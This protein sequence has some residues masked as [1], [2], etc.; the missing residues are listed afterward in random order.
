LSIVLSLILKPGQRVVIE[1]PTYS[2]IIN[3]LRA[4]R[5]DFAAV[6]LD[7]DGMDVAALESVLR[8]G[9]CGAI[10]AIPTFHNPT[11]ITM[12]HERRLHLLRLA[13]QYGVPIVEDDWGPDLHYEGKRHSPLKSLDRGGYVIHIGTYS[14][15]FLPGLRLGWITCPSRMA[16]ALLSA[17]SSI[18]RGDSFFL[19]ALMCEFI[20]RGHYARHLRHCLG[21]YRKR[22]NAL[23]RLLTKLLPPGCSFMMPEGGF[24][25]WVKLPPGVM[26]LPLQALAREAGVE[27]LPAAYCVPDRRDTSALRLSF[28]RTEVGEIEQGIPLLCGLIDRCLAEPGLLA[29]MT[30]PFEELHK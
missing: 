30:R 29:A 20:R 28:S 13:A 22:R 8:E 2:A 4:E 27:F 3:L 11:G 21:E 12:G 7:S 24:S 23:C 26:S 19:Q 6:P 9:G 25:V 15:T 18:D 10:I 16:F 17:K 5:I 14:K 1:T